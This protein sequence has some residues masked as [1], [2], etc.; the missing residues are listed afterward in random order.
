MEVTCERCGTVYDF[1]DALV[2]ERGTSV[3]CTTCGHQFKVRRASVGTVP[4]T[5]VVRTVDG[6]EIEFS[7][8]RELQGAIHDGKVTRDD[9]LSRGN[10]RPRRLGSIAELD[11]FFN[12]IGMTV[13]GTGTTPP[14]PAARTRT[15]TPAG[16]GGGA[17]QPPRQEGS[18][19]FALPGRQQQAPA[20]AAPPMAMGGA[21]LGR[22]PAS[23]RPPASA[24]ADKG[25]DMPA[26]AAPRV[27]GG[28]EELNT[29]DVVEAPISTRN[30]GGFGSPPPM[31]AQAG[32]SSDERGGTVERISA[33]P[34]PPPPPRKPAG[35]APMFPSPP[36]EGP[37]LPRKTAPSS[38]MF[39]PP[40]PPPPPRKAA[41]SAPMFPPPEPP[42]LPRKATPEPPNVQDA[43]PSSGDDPTLMME[44]PPTS[45][46]PTLMMDRPPALT[47]GKATPAP[48]KAEPAKPISSK[49]PPATPPSSGPT[50]LPPSS[51][52]LHSDDV[53]SVSG[54]P[55]RRPHAARWI[56]GVLL[57][58]AGALG[59]V[60]VGREYLPKGSGAAAST[61][62]DARLGALL[63]QGDRDLRDGDLDA[64]NES[65]VKAS[66]I[67]DADLRVAVRLARLAVVRADVAWLKVRLLGAS[68]PDLPNARRELDLAVGRAKQAADRAQSIAAADADVTRCRID[69]LRLAGDM[70][71]ARKLVATLPKATPQASDE[72]LFATL[73]LA[74]AAPVWATV[75]ERLRAAARDE[76]NLGRARSMLIYAL[77]RSG[78]TAGAKVELDRLAAMPRPHPLVASL[79]AFMASAEGAK[80]P[81]VEA[82]SLKV[83][84]GDDALK[85]AI[86]AI[87]KGEFD[88]AEPLL[89]QLAEK[90]PKDTKV[91]KAQGDFAQKKRDRAAAIRFYEQAVAADGTNLDAV[92]AL[93]DLRW[94]NGERMTA[95]TLYRKIIEKGGDA[96]PHTK[97]AKERLAKFADSW[98]P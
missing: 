82:A 29:M 9:V 19:V 25:S 6:R 70:D 59:A 94:E 63:D 24:G 81:E 78:D 3:K 54:V 18:V 30:N 58:G 7:A 13:P 71:G 55:P 83:E 4:D 65:Y 56:V 90:T 61:Q 47:A 17:A 21:L 88:K 48:P 42:P 31:R 38:P 84:A 80:K 86:E 15:R 1:D 46:G 8:L 26:L 22:R 87:E 37:P 27:P 2:S 34:P 89:K 32:S 97:R 60:M 50:S 36:A 5:W 51:A 91:L 96:N 45:E 66:A 14:P 12:R 85:S 76:Q 28:L 77:A 93:A 74:E 43:G 41:A 16:L 11:P 75:I 92:A 69:A 52:L 57:L 10:S 39:P 64:A 33:L 44:R 79:R 72:L 53:L 95:S 67:A 73:D 23:V 98:E 20:A 40:E 68:D 62:G 35:S 49:S